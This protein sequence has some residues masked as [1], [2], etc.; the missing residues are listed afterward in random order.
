MFKL[1]S[2]TRGGFVQLL[3]LGGLTLMLS[4]CG[5]GGGRRGR[6]AGGCNERTG[7]TGPSCVIAGRL[8]SGLVGR[9][10]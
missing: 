4:A 8:D 9:G 3:T 1:I 7:P 2:R 6:L 10:S 5:G